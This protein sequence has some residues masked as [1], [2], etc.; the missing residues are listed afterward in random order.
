MNHKKTFLYNS[1][2]NGMLVSGNRRVV[3]TRLALLLKS[4]V[5]KAY[6]PYAFRTFMFVLKWIPSRVFFIQVS[7]Y[8]YYIIVYMIITFSKS[9]LVYASFSLGLIECINLMVSL[10]FAFSWVLHPIN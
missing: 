9:L 6:W 5:Y 1:G 7:L 2:Q 3:D 8:P 10:L 4:G